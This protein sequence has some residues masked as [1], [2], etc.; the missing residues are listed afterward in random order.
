MITLQ[1]ALTEE[2]HLEFNYYRWWKSPSNRNWR[3]KQY[4]RYV[5]IYAI[6]FLM[7]PLINHRPLTLNWVV[8]MVV[9]LGVMCLLLPV[10]SKERIR[11]NVR[12]LLSDPANARYLA[13]T[14]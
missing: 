9:I 8:L 7:M 4:L 11:R 13:Q 2:D 12:K 1:Y 10:L 3:V 6:V 5:L 14:E